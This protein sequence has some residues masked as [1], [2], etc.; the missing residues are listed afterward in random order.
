ML[1]YILTI[2]FGACVSVAITAGNPYEDDNNDDEDYENVDPVDAKKNAGK[3]EEEESDDYEEPENDEDHDYEEAGPDAN[4]VKEVCFI[5]EDNREDESSDDENDYVNVT[6]SS[7]EQ[8]MDIYVEHEDTYQNFQVSTSRQCYIDTIVRELIFAVLKE[9]LPVKQPEQTNI[10]YSTQL[11]LFW[12]QESMIV[13]QY[14]FQIAISV[15]AY[16]VQ[17]TL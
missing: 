17:Y 6:Q 4:Y 3:V 16:S 11:G 2:S 5:V 9:Q 14:L 8:T 13:I 10:E 15:Q 7:V 1:S 12:P